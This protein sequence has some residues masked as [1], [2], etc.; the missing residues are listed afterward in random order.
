MLDRSIP[1]KS[2]LKSE[3][4]TSNMVKTWLCLKLGVPSPMDYHHVPN[5]FPYVFHM[6]SIYVHHVPVISHLFPSISHTF[7]TKRWP[8]QPPLPG[9][10]LPR[11]IVLGQARQAGGR[12]D[13]FVPMA[14]LRLCWDGWDGPW[15]NGGMVHTVPSIYV[16]YTMLFIS[17]IK[18]TTTVRKM[19]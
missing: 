6:F 9:G 8:H 3:M 7:P 17:S 19:G 13:P 12:F 5:M 18:Y 14:L 1:K 16:V 2:W 4:S 15:V 11:G 10:E